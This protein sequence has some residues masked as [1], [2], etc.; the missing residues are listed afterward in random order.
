MGQQ[1]QL[2][3]DLKHILP[4]CSSLSIPKT[5]HVMLCIIDN[6]TDSTLASG[7][8]GV[9]IYQETSPLSI[10]PRKNSISL[11]TIPN[12]ISNLFLCL[13]KSTKKLVMLGNTHKIF[14][15]AWSFINNWV[16][17]KLKYHQRTM[18]HQNSKFSFNSIV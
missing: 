18:M 13:T 15:W 7:S 2:N 16:M 9:L 17:V 10:S 14:I 3:T 8:T 12:Y 6:A 4:Y 5:M 11:K 1:S